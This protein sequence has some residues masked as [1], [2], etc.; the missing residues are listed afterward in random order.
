M[1]ESPGNGSSPQTLRKCD[2]NNLEELML[3]GNINK[4]GILAK[5]HAW[6]RNLEAKKV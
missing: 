4:G 1:I 2:L 5:S 6:D 3:Q